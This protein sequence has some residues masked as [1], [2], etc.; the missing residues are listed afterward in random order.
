MLKKKQIIV[1]VSGGFD[2]IHTGH[3]KL[4]K[5]AKVLGDKLVVILNSDKWLI[6]KK[7][8]CFMN[9]AERKGIIKELKSVDDVYVHHSNKDNVCGALKVLKPNIFDNGGDRR[10]KKYIT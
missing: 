7:G 3:I 2:P 5:A 9:E 10:S 1:V 8:K 4:F 6:K